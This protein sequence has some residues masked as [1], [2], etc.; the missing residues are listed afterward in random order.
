M[1]KSYEELQTM[2]TDA[3][4]QVPLGSIWKHYKDSEAAYE[5]KDIVIIE[6]TKEVGVVY[7][8]ESQPGVKFVRPLSEFFED[9]EFEGKTIKRFKNVN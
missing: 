2:L 1:K 3:A 5:I 7:E 8:P 4:D 9:V 6:S